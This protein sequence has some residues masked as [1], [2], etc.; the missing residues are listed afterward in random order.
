[1]ATGAI[2]TEETRRAILDRKDQ[3][4]T[5]LVERGHVARFA[6]AI[7]D[8]NPLFHDQQAASGSRYGGLIAPPTF[9]R[10]VETRTPSPPE[11]A[12]LTSVLDGGSEWE[13]HEPVRVGDTITAVTRITSVRERVISV[14]PAVFLAGET[15][16]SNQSGR[17]VARQR[18]TFIRY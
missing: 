18:F 8:P 15:L 3:A 9:L 14:G 17:A 16:Y 6:E 10:A 12:S 13:Y 1:M 4:A 5:L 11:L 7:G 2:L